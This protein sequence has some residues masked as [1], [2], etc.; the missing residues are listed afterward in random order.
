MAKYFILTLS[1]RVGRFGWTLIL[2]KKKRREMDPDWHCQ[3]GT[4]VRETK[5]PWR[6]HEG[7]ELCS[8][9]S[10]IRPFSFVTVRVRFV[11]VTYVINYF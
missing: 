1:F 2:S 3:L 11:T 4:W 10:E 7:V 6:L 9:D 5:L 8:L